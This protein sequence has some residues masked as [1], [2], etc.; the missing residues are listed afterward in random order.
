MCYLRAQVEGRE[1]TPVLAECYGGTF[2]VWS[3]KEFPG[4]EVS[5]DLT[6]ARQNIYQACMEN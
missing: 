6:K 4:L 5:T 1:P 3:A 2:T